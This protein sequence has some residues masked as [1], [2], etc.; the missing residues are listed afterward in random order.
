MM[1]GVSVSYHLSPSVLGGQLVFF[2][3]AAAHIRFHTNFWHTP[4]KT[5]GTRRGTVMR[6]FTNTREGLD[7]QLAVNTYVT[8][9]DT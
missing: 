7:R 5:T 1:M 3:R 6:R 9:N 8:D 4:L 2:L